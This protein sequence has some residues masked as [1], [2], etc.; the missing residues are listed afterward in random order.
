MPW[1]LGPSL[2][3][4]V[5]GVQRFNICCIAWFLI[6]LKQVLKR[7]SILSKFIKVS[8][9]VFV[10]YSLRKTFELV[11]TQWCI[12]VVKKSVSKF[13]KVC[14]SCWR[15]VLYKFCCIQHWNSLKFQCL[16]TAIWNKNIEHVD[17]VE[18]TVWSLFFDVFTGSPST[19]VW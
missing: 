10:V 12:Y 16:T 9:L 4:N 13:N 8:K 18:N 17:G 11:W 2:C 15:I 7:V 19:K 6:N 14:E 3:F 1:K 5:P